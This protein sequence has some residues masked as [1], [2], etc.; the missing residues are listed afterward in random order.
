MSGEHVVIGQAVYE[1]QGTPQARRQGQE[2]RAQVSPRLDV[3]VPQ[4][5]LGVVGVIEGP[6]RYRG[7]G[8][9]G[10]EHVGP[11][12]HG[13]RRQVPPERPA[14]Y[15]HP[16]EV[17]VLDLTG[18]TVKGVHLVLEHRPGQVQVHFTLEGRPSPR[19][20]PAVRHHHGK[21]LVGEPLGLQP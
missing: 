15:G 16:G 14:P 8:D 19:R 17:E 1:Q 3:G 6:V 10:V 11:G 13:Q 21:T 20:A 4:E 7:A 2:R 9:G 5:T 18:S 12:Q